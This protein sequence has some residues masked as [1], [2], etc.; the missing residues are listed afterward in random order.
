MDGILVQDSDWSRKLSTALYD[1][2]KQKVLCDLGI[3]CSP[4]NDVTNIKSNE[5]VMVH[6]CVLSAASETIKR[7]SVGGQVYNLVKINGINISIDC[8]NSVLEFVYCGRTSVNGSQLCDIRKAAHVL[9][10]KE[11]ERAVDA[12]HAGHPLCVCPNRDPIVNSINIGS[13]SNTYTI[14]CDKWISQLFENMLDLLVKQTLCNMTIITEKADKTSAEILAHLC[15]LV[16]ASSTIRELVLQGSETYNSVK[17]DSIAYNTWLYLLEYV[18]TS[19]VS[20]VKSN[21][22]E[23]WVASQLL[24]IDGLANAVTPFASQ[25]TNGQNGSMLPQL[26]APSTSLTPMS[27][28]ESPESTSG[29]HDKDSSD[30]DKSISENSEKS[31]SHSPHMTTQDLLNIKSEL[32]QVESTR[33]LD[34]DNSI[35][36]SLNSDSCDLPNSSSLNAISTLGIS[37]SDALNS[38]PSIGESSL[39]DDGSVLCDIKSELNTD[40]PSLGSDT[41][42]ALADTST[43]LPGVQLS[44]A[45]PENTPQSLLGGAIPAASLLQNAQIIPVP[46]GAGG[47]VQTAQQLGCKYFLSNNHFMIG[48]SFFLDYSP[49]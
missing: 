14:A 8:W 11:L 29:F 39:N 46:T 36:L 40:L 47:L 37:S 30:Q 17:I 20:I 43:T 13:A 5:V 41:P 45:T 38:D 22:P 18:Y 28:I 23:V 24:Q 9:Q 4:Q 7:L 6:R 49:Y 19:R 3:V 10:I 26:Q 48:I 2:L 44:A 12:H 15:M 25:I 42:V 31:H 33:T 35:G 21:I 16:A 27:T 34:D 32:G 1:L